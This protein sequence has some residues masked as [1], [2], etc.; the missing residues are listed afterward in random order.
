MNTQ[1]NVVYMMQQESKAK[2]QKEE[3]TR[4]ITG[5]GSITEQVMTM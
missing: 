2:I 5:P 1:K 4:G 3:K